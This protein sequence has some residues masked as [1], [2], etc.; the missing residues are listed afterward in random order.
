MKT[1]ALSFLLAAVYAAF[2]PH[3]QA[4]SKPASTKFYVNVKGHLASPGGVAMP[5]ATLTFDKPFQVPRVNLPAGSYLFTMVTPNTMRVSSEDGEKI[6]ATFS[7][8]PSTRSG[9][10]NHAQVRFERVN[11]GAAIRLI[12][13]YL[14][15]SSSGYAP[16]YSKSHKQVDAPVATSGTVG[17]K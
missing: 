7:T 15:G 5:S 3:A 4:Q 2:A 16:L 14:E 17:E 13:V 1:I 11:N 6:Y 10:L 12:G 8:S 9:D